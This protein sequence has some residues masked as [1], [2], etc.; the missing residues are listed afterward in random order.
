MNTRALALW[1]AAGTGIQVGAAMVAT[2]YVVDATGPA[3]LGF[4]RY[5][6]G[7]LCLIPALLLQPRPSI[8]AR[9]VVPIGLL[10]VGQ[11]G[12]LIVLLNFAMLH[13]PAARASLLFSTFPLMTL[14]LAVS[15]R[16]DVLTTAKVVGSALC[17]AGVG[18]A[19]GD[20]A[21]TPATAGQVPWL[22]AAAALGAAF[23]GAACSIGYR[24]YVTRY[25]A[26]YVTA[27]AMMIAVGFLGILAAG[28]GFFA[29][30]PR[31][32]A[33]EWA[34]VIF[35]GVSS[36]LG[37]FLWV[38]ALGNAPPM[39]VTMFLGLSPITAAL[40]GT[41]L[42]GEPLPTA[43]LIGLGCVIAGLGLALRASR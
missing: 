6:I 31:F 10:G 30:R 9:D 17:V 29:A 28:E 38:F 14:L 42:L 24:T 37:F 20:D 5:A 16:R 1:A 2:R 11:F 34:A 40:G 21:L 36:G 8:V 33:G 41:L 32:T 26:L 7:L 43:A 4:L 39:L 23:C 22:G 15:L 3:S 13:I 25:T 18:I 12:I 35:I 27:L 19:L